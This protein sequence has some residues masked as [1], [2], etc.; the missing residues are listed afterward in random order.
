M[1][2]F[3][4]SS[5]P[6]RRRTPAIQTNTENGTKAEESTVTRQLPIDQPMPHGDA[7]I[8]NN[9]KPVKHVRVQSPPPSSPEDAIEDK[10]HTPLP[11]GEGHAL[12]HDPFESVMSDESSDDNDEE[13]PPIIAASNDGRAPIPP[14]SCAGNDG[15]TSMNPFSKTLATL[16]RTEGKESTGETPPV[17]SGK[18]AMDVESFKRLLMTGSSGIPAPE[19]LPGPPAQSA[20]T[21]PTDGSS[22]EA[23]SV[24]RHSIF[25]NIQENLPE[26]PRT[27]HEVSDAN[28]EPRRMPPTLQRSA[29]GRKKPP[30]PSSR[31]GKLIN[32]QLRDN[33][34]PHSLYLTS[35]SA[36]SPL[37]T[38]I[39]TPT[40]AE[41]SATD[42]NKPLP[43]NPSRASHDSD[44]E[45]VFDC[46]S[47]GKAPEPSSPSNLLRRKPAPAPPSARR[48]GHPVADPNS[49]HLSPKRLTNM[50]DDS[51]NS[52]TQDLSSLHPSTNQQATFKAP[53]PPP[54][55]RPGSIRNSVISPPFITSELENAPSMPRAPSTPSKRLSVV[56]PA[57]PRPRGASGAS[58]DA[59]LPNPAASTTEHPDILAD[60]GALQREIDALRGR[61]A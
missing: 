45:S 60:L 46:E 30:P 27:S 21:G 14:I 40:A 9:D 55:R 36:P 43:P 7:P 20:H 31:H 54:L 33:A 50:G 6:F 24:S 42:L 16:E 1:A 15:R 47:V 59:N 2:D 10:S 41:R 4:G 3:H 8:K 48:H 52:S 37:S 44:R 11:Q 39:P 17:G 56:P 23:S 29:S 22:T 13:I 51:R 34:R 18:A 32:V 35:T 53:P 38:T 26:S 58:V 61:E 19:S 25:E 28:D 57:P 12:G 5:N 49:P